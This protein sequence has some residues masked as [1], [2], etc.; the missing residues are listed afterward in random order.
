MLRSLDASATPTLDD[1]A[2]DVRAAKRL[3]PAQAE[4]MQL[5]CVAVLAALRE[6]A[7]QQVAPIADDRLIDAEQV[8][9]LIGFSKSWV[10]KNIDKLPQRVSVEGAPRWLLSVVLAWMKARPRYPATS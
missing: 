5:G 8:A 6:R 7:A 1:I 2:R 3:S 9:A 4:E 10:E